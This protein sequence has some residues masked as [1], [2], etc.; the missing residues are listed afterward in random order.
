MK[1]V[2]VFDSDG[3]GHRPEHA[4]TLIV[5]HYNKRRRFRQA[6]DAAVAE[7]KKDAPDEWNLDQ[8]FA[9][10]AKAGW[11]VIRVDDSVEVEY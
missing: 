7:A 3:A 10:L 2:N 8:V 1:I 5:N 11:Q 6:W 4:M 9:L